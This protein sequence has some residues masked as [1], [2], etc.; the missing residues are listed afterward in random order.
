MPCGDAGMPGEQGWNNTVSLRIRGVLHAAKT[1]GFTK[2]VLG[3][4]GCGAFGN[5]PDHVAK[6]FREELSSAEFRGAFRQIVFA[7]IDP[8]GD[9]NYHPFLDEIGKMDESRSRSDGLDTP[10]ACA[11]ADESEQIES[12]L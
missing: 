11:V 8:R 2:L 10:V 4:W 3:A 1:S 6:I 7:I 5:P 9:G 12:H